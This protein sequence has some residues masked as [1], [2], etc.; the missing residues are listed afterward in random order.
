MRFGSLLDLFKQD[1]WSNKLVARVTEMLELSEAM[2]KHA[3]SV[4][5]DG[6]ED[7]DPQTNIYARDQR[8][9][10]L[11]RKTRRR[12]ISR[13]SVGNETSDVPTALIFMNVVK[14]GERLGDYI[15]NLH[16]VA[17]MMPENPDRNLY[18][19]WLAGPTETIGGMFAD[20]RRAFAESDE[21][22]A[23]Q[24]IKTAKRMGRELEEAIREIT[25]SDLP[26]QDA[27]CLVLVLRFYKRLVAHMSN[28]ASTVTMPVDLI[29]FYDEPDGD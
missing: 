18:R 29:D 3:S 27:V 2:F 15:K 11:E 20:T 7:T 21:A 26:T 23:G 14:D 16:E 5:V 25:T 4:I 19:K 13:L 17:G 10:Q 8:I 24:V 22:Q 6:A 1:N 12:V 28:I 9:N